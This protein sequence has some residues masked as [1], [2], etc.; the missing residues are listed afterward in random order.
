MHHIRR[1]FRYLR[2]YPREL[3]GT[4]IFNLLHVIFNLS[5]YVLIIP[6]VELLFGMSEPPAVEPELALNQHALTDWMLWNLYQLK[7]SWGLWRCLITA[8]AAYLTCSLLSNVCRYMGYY[9]VGPIRQGMIQ[10]LRDDIYHKITILPVSYFN[11]QRHGD[12]LSRMSN[13]LLDIEWSIVTSLLSIAKDPINILLFTGTLL[14]ISPRLF[15]YFLLVLP[16]S[17]LLIVQIGKSLKR[18][19]SKGQ[20]KL[21]GIFSVLEE[22]LSNIRVI[23]SFGRESNQIHRFRHANSDYTRTMVRVA[24]RRELSAPLSEVL[25]TIGLV[26][27]LI[28]GGNMVIHGEMLSSVFIFFIIIFARLIPPIQSLVRAYNNLQKG[29]ASAERFFELLDADETILEV[30]DAQVIT[31]F[32]HCIEYDDVC[33]AYQRG[34][35]CVPVLDH[36]SLRIDKGRTIAIV[37]PSGAG[38]TTLVDLLPRFYDPGSGEIRIDGTPIRQLN[39]GALRQQIGLVSQ[40]CILFNDTIAHN[41]AFGHEHYSDEAVQAAARAAYADSFIS[42]LPEG[43]N[44]L[45]GDRGVMLSGGQRQRISIARALLKNPPILILDE[46]TSALDA[47]SEH[48]VQQALNSLMQGR[49]SIVIAH[50]LSTIQNADEIWVMDKGRIVQRGT[51]SSL[52]QEEG[53][54][55]KL[56]EMQT[57]AL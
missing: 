26:G 27:I 35:E 44:T 1:I 14:F 16:P 3:V 46:A 10:R 51:H 11:S 19:S 17:V 48:V 20:R 9:C 15:L 55:R 34:N 5:S 37:G 56:V 21:G 13:D 33:F 40:N 47:E 49:T 38:K 52:L 7:D 4:V 39:I 29:N 57:F 54:Y 41:I 23:K 8:S 36:V 45:I 32:N 43:Y 42:A 30:P 24:M 50:R 25:G 31:G 2:F 18:N 28:L 12:L 53:L 22:S 6:F